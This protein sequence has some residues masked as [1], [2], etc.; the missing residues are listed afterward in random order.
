MGNSEKDDGRFQGY[1]VE[2]FSCKY[3]LYCIETK[4]RK[5]RC[6]LAVCPYKNEIGEAVNAGR[7]KSEWK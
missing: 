2:D 5:V 7:I 1:T 6:K 4:H 3:C